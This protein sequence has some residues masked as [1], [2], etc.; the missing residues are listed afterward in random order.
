MARFLPVQK[1]TATNAIQEI[2]ARVET[3]FGGSIPNLFKTAASS[4][5]F[6]NAFQ[7]FFTTIMINEC[8]VNDKIRNLAVLKASKL[9]KDNYL[10]ILA[11]EWGKK[12]GLT[13]E[14]IKAIDNHE[15][16]ESFTYDEKLVL[17]Y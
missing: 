5:S 2:Y 7:I 10:T 8:S 1:D 13:D 3:N 17:S 16:S 11:T 6:L 4:G 14:Q 9:N 15:K 12:L